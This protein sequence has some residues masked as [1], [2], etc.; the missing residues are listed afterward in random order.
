[1]SS[2]QPCTC[3]Y[4]AGT[5]ATA[6]AALQLQVRGGEAVAALSA[7]APGEGELLQRIQQL[8][9]DERARL[10]AH[11]K[12]DA[13]KKGGGML[14]GS[15]TAM[16]QRAA[17][18]RAAAAELRQELEDAT[19]A[20]WRSFLDVLDVLVAKGAVDAHTLEVLPL[21]VVARS[22][23]CANELWMALALTQ[24]A[25]AGLTGPQ[26]AA[27]LAALLAGDTLRRASSVWTA[28]QVSPALVQV[29][30]SLE[31][32]REALCE[33]QA[34]MGLGKWNE[35][36]QVDL[37]L[38]GLVEAWAQGVAWRDMMADCELED[39]DVARLLF[40][41]VDMLRQVSRCSLMLPWIR[42]AATQAV[43]AM[44]RQPVTGDVE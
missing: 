21:G 10:L 39:G 18:R 4:V 38:S 17:R 6:V 20:T 11:A 9:Q 3:W 15:V 41:T 43:S 26:L 8:Q 42:E 16:R 1:M 34:S 27:L 19:A 23:Q 33:V 13:R 40:R 12:S 29:V 30:E 2:P 44:D 5:G 32:E 28:Y 36:M 35:S 24:P 22:L 7:L 14:D 25:V 37:R 31:C